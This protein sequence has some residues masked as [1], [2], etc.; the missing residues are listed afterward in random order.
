MHSVTCYYRRQDAL[1][2]GE[3]VGPER[4]GCLRLPWSSGR[5]ATRYDRRIAVCIAGAPRVFTRPHVHR[6]IA[7]MLLKPLVEWVVD[8]FASLVM[9]DQRPS[10]DYDQPDWHATAVNPSVEEVSAALSVLRP[11]AVVLVNESQAVVNPRCDLNGF[12]AT[13]TERFMA[14]WNTIGRCLPLIEAAETTDAF[15]YTHVIRTRPDLFWA[16]PHAAPDAWQVNVSLMDRRHPQVDWHWVV[17]RMVAATALRLY[18]RYQA[19]NVSDKARAGSRW[20]FHAGDNEHMVER[21]L[22]AAGAPMR[23]TFFP[24]L[25]VRESRWLRSARRAEMCSATYAWL[26]YNMTCTELYRRAYPLA[27]ASAFN[28]SCSLG[29]AAE[30]SQ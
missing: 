13:H 22:R 6:S 1:W 27:S 18:A 9:L 30:A 2:A 19:C 3:L 10:S 14:Q 5:F 4:P 7:N 29:C 17:P 24:M 11:R 15:A 28:T 25:L 23:E 26:A 16:L 20:V 21:V 8:V 12:L